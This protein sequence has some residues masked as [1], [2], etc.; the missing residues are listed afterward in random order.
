MAKSTMVEFYELDEQRTG[1]GFGVKRF[2]SKLNS[3]IARAMALPAHIVREMA[4]KDEAAIRGKMIS[5][6]CG[7][8]EWKNTCLACGEAEIGIFERECQPCQLKKLFGC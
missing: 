7:H 4:K 2:V 3:D 1:H 8:P 6:S 5:I